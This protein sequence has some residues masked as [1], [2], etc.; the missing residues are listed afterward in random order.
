MARQQKRGGINLP[1]PIAGPEKNYVHNKMKQK[2][3]VFGWSAV[4]V[5]Q[6]RDHGCGNAGKRMRWQQAAG[7]VAE[8]SGLSARIKRRDGD[9][10]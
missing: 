9:A 2:G 4:L 7:P 6:S 3:G 1:V 10:G 8:P 5:L